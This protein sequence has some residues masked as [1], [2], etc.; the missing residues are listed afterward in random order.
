MERAVGR[1]VERAVEGAPD[2]GEE[3]DDE[4][5]Q[6]EQQHDAH[7]VARPLDAREQLE[8][9]AEPQQLGRLQH[10]GHLQSRGCGGHSR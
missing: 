9:A 6:H 4:H 7:G 8:D 3:V 1:A 5:E 10:L 2:A